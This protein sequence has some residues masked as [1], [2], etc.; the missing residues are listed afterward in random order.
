MR[1]F[2]L[3]GLLLAA[4]I[5]ALGQTLGD[6][7][8]RVVQ[9]NANP[10]DQPMALRFLGSTNRDFF[11]IER[12]SGKVNLV[13]GT[14][15]TT[16]LDLPVATRGL[17]GAHSGLVGLELD[18]NFRTNGFV[19]LRYSFSNTG[20]DSSAV[21]TAWQEDRVSRFHWNG[22]NLDSEQVLLTIPRLNPDPNPYFH[23][24][25]PLTFGADGK[26][27]GI[28]GDMNRRFAEENQTAQ[29]T[30]SSKS[31][32]IFRIN[33]DGT[34]PGDNPFVGNANADFHRWFAYGIRNS[35][36][37]TTDPLTGR[38]WDTENGAVE[39]DEINLV[40][41]GM[42]LGWNG[43]EVSQGP[44]V[45]GSV[46]TVNLAGVDTYSNPEFS[47]K[48]DVGITS[49]TFLSGSQLPAADYGN[50][51]LVAD[52]NTAQLYLLQLNAN[53]DGFVFNNPGQ[54]VLAD[55]VAD[56]AAEA[57]TLVIGNGFVVPVDMRVG[58]DKALYLLSHAT[59][60]NPSG[61][62]L[63]IELAVD[64]AKPF[65]NPAEP[66]DVDHDGVIVP[67]DALLLIDKINAGQGGTL[68]N[69]PSTTDPF[70]VYLDP[71]GDNNLAPL[72]ALQV[73]DHLNAQT[74]QGAGS[75]SLL[76]LGDEALLAAP[77]SAASLQSPAQNVPEPAAGLLALLAVTGLVL[78][79][80]R[81]RR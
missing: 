50:G 9:I 49:L 16:V 73:I 28:V 30:T 22:T 70:P 20:G 40:T 11:Y 55:L 62:L 46:P 12:Q 10:Y 8:L 71:S 79:R 41:S 39:N 15:Q 56:T 67:L 47:L 63:R 66:L 80:R 64:P 76:S 2:L 18:P 14:A 75:F 77:L 48:D 60:A 25:G 27:Y 81:A 42:N 72:D 24:G 38:L 4:A 44:R 36:G 5:P 19:Y 43:L 1:S 74:G 68:T 21:E 52:N 23:V 7:R 78:V 45:P 61:S 65:R 57:S 69:P 53:R 13:S 35:V 17:G 33:T 31:S 3:F 58:P 37:L 59:S 51:V 32:G 29:S 34:I 54:S 6:S 26:L